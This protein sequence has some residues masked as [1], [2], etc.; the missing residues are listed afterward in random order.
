MP[1]CREPFPF[2][3]E[4][5]LRSNPSLPIQTCDGCSTLICGRYFHWCAAN[6]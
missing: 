5:E 1:H 6:W 2:Y 3:E 4:D